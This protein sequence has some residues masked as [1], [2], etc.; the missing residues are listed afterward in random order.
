M[1]NLRF[2][3]HFILTALD[4]NILESSRYSEY[5]SIY[6]FFPNPPGV[7]FFHSRIA[8]VELK[9]PWTFED[10]EYP[11]PLMPSSPV[12]FSD[13]ADSFG[14]TISSYIDQ[15]KQIYLMW[16]GGIDSTVVA[17]SVLKYLRDNQRDHLHIVLSNASRVEHPVFYHKFLKSLD[18][19]E[20]TDFD[21]GK[22][23]LVN[24]IITDGEG[25]DQIFGS[26]AINKVFSI[27]PDK[28]YLPW[29]DNQDFLKQFWYKDSV[30][31]FYDFLMHI[32]ET[33]IKHT[34]VPVITLY[35]FFWWL[36]FNFKF[37]SVMYR[38]T[39][40]LGENV[41]DK[42]FEYFSNTTIYRLFATEKMQQWSMGAGAQEKL[43]QAR[44]TIKW[45]ARKY[46]YEFDCNEYYFREKRKEFS[47][48]TIA[49]ATAKHIAIDKDYKR[50]TMAER[51]I[52]Q[53]I[54]KTFFPNAVG[55]IAI[56]AVR[57]WTNN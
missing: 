6:R 28:I 21:P 48:S 32:M 22:L 57:L 40:R 16:S 13:A 50:Y 29:R 42:D 27:Y 3:N 17:V 10:T 11:V 36:N 52:R 45:A 43:N 18:Q 49:D 34:S 14:A 55:R 44:K 38:H 1:N 33:T 5:T 46:I 20:L 53:D 8:G 12:S 37:E 56:P 19:I 26:A 54:R 25:G 35:D 9:S 2:L 4:P 51:S 39:L 23:D 7:E 15:G 47:N 41:N 24:S 31:G 30:P